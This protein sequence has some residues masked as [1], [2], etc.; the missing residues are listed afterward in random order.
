VQKSWQI[1]P[2]NPELSNKI[3]SALE[4]SP[5]IAQILLNRKIRSLNQAKNFLDKDPVTQ[6]TNFDNR[7]FV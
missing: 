3:G 2:T 6:K 4:T 1:Y 7:V 5:V